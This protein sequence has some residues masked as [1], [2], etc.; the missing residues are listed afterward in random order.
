MR[1]TN[2]E[3][4][5]LLLILISCQP[6]DHKDDLLW[7]DEFEYSGPPDVEKWNYQLGNGCPEICGWGNNEQQY[8]TDKP[9]NVR[10]EDGKLIIEAHQTDDEKNFTSA[11]LT[12]ENKGDWKSGYIEVNAKLPYGRGTWPA[13][14]MLP[15]LERAL[16]WPEDGEIDIMEH[17]GYNQ[18]QIYGTIHTQAFNHMKGTHKSDSIF[19]S[20]ASE[21]FHTYA[22]NWTEEKIEW[23]V[24]DRM[25][26]TISKGT[27]DNSGWPFTKPFH[28][29]INLAVG[30]NWGGKY[31]VDEHIWPQ[32]MEIDFVRVY[33]SKPQIL[34]TTD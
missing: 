2:L 20:D 19:I 21:E 18:G 24:D 32:R 17:V 10:V 13:I 11:K 15:S 3:F 30:G 16:N 5:L 26:Q 27:E 7:S 29:I 1:R 31:G 34:S 12:S 8:Y 23:Y 6:T 22:I 25:F 14:W 28:L 9:T 33:R 4:L